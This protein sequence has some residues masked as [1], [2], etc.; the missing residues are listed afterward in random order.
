MMPWFLPL[1]IAV[2]VAGTRIAMRA[3]R[4]IRSTKQDGG[5]WLLPLLS[6]LPLACWILAQFVTQD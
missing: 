2:G 6:W 3:R 1:G 4:A 5:W